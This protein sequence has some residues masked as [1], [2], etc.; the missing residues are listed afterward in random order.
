MPY[1]FQT[2]A[3]K[4]KL[5]ANELDGLGFRK[6]YLIRIDICQ[7]NG[8]SFTSR[9]PNELLHHFWLVLGQDPENLVR[10][11]SCR[12]PRKSFRVTYKVRE[13]IHLPHISADAKFDFYQVPN[14]DPNYPDVKLTVFQCVLVSGSEE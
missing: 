8:T 9:L 7:Q 1:N 3:T 5:S 12:I 11:R 4:S 14:Q 10:F 13:P 6:A 2:T